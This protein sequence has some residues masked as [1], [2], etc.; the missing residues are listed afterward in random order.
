M[1]Y[2][3]PK[4]RTEMAIVSSHIPAKVADRLQEIADARSKET[5]KFVSVSKVVREILTEYT[6][7]REP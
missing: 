2:Q 1:I 4:Y 7:E 5:G 3:T 6:A